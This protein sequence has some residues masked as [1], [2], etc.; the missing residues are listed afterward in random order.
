MHRVDIQCHCIFRLHDHPHSKRITR[1]VRTRRR[2]EWTADTNPRVGE[3]AREAEARTA[4]VPLDVRGGERA[5]LLLHVLV[6]R[7]R[8]RAVHINLREERELGPVALSELLHL[9]V[10]AGL[11]P[12][13]LVAGERQN[14][15]ALRLVLVVQSRKLLRQWSRWR[16][17]ETQTAR[18]RDDEEAEGGG[19]WW[20]SGSEGRHLVVL[21]R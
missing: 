11:L 20:A 16:G 7:R 1:V 8:G 18:A 21:G 6:Q 10:G 4:E 2:C 17:S 12:T 19:G 15:K 5:L 3:S 14:L 9:R 13:K